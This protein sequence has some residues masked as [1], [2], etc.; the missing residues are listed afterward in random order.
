MVEEQKSKLFFL[1]IFPKCPFYKPIPILII[2]ALIVFGTWGIYYLNLWVAVGYLV[3]SLLFYFLL[4]PFTICKYCYFKVKET[5][6]DEE[7]GKTIEKLLSVDQWSKSHL[8]KHV[9]QKHW[10]WLMTIIWFLPII[11]IVISFFMDFSYLALIALI[12][13]IAALVGFVIY[14]LKIKCPSCPI[15]EQCHSSF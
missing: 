15:Q 6:I 3:Y 12:G 11:L 13:F 4:M 14:L 2:L 1:G 7:K 10:T 9:G 8:H 5:T